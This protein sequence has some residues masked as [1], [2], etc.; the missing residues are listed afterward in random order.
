MEDDIRFYFSIDEEKFGD[1]CRVF[2]GIC[3]AAIHANLV[4]NAAF[5]FKKVCIVIMRR[6]GMNLIPLSDQFPHKIHPEI[7]N[8]PGRIQNNSNSHWALV[9]RISGSLSDKLPNNQV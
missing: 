6:N 8:V 1:Q 5:F 3:S 4:M 7:V 2:Y 9:M